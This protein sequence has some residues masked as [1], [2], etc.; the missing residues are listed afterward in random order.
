MKFPTE[1]K[2]ESQVPVTTNQILTIIDRDQL[3]LTI[4]HHY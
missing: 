2:N 3:L 4:I 1:W